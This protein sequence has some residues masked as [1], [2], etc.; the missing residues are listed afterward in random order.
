[1]ED[2]HRATILKI[3]F[4]RVMQRQGETEAFVAEFAT[5]L[6]RFNDLPSFDR[7]VTRE[8]FV[9]SLVK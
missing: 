6:Q 4:K 2:N 1:M 7:G 9:Q 8:D 5:D 3:D